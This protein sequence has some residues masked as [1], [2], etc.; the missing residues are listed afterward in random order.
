MLL[1]KLGL[2]RFVSCRRYSLCWSSIVCT[3]RLYRSIGRELFISRSSRSFIFTLML[4]TSFSSRCLSPSR[5]LSLVTKTSSKWLEHTSLWPPVRLWGLLTFHWRLTQL[6]SRD[7]YWCSLTCVS[8]DS[9]HTA[10]HCPWKHWKSK[11]RKLLILRFGHYT[12]AIQAERSIDT[13]WLHDAVCA[14]ADWPA[15]NFETSI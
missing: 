14:S 12:T 2:K 10:H 8:N 7:K 11:I 9:I 6:W 1:N 15:G 3:K 4:A 13:P 5:C